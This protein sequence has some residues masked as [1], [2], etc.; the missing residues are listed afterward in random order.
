VS[1]YVPRE[2]DQVRATVT[3]RVERLLAH[4]NAVLLVADSGHTIL[5]PILDDLGAADVTWEPVNPAP[6]WSRGDL[7]RNPL[8]VLYERTD[9]PAGVWQNLRDPFPVTPSCDDGWVNAGIASG[10]LTAL[11][12]NGQPVAGS[13]A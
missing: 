10:M 13:A 11:V 6:S 9:Q 12:R 7:V 4:R 3:G 5:L 8:G 1:D 2:G